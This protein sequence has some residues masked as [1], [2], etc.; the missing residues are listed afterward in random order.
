MQAIRTHYLPPTNNRGARV[1]ATAQAG[2]IVYDWQDASDVPEN[3]RQAAEAFARV[4]GWERFGPMHSGALPDGS[5]AHV[6]ARD[7]DA[8]FRRLTP[9][10]WH[11]ERASEEIS[12]H[13]AAGS[14]VCTMP[15]HGAEHDAARIVACVN[16]CEGYDPAALREVVN[17]ARLVSDFNKLR[18]AIARLDGAE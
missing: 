14:R 2:R 3:H 12:V 9:G 11:V 13:D 18:A 6:F 10:P 5:Y 17:L 7:D 15:T 16:A 1:V 4:W 8:T